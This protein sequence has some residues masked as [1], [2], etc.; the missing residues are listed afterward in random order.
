VPFRRRRGGWRV[1]WRIGGWRGWRI[2]GWHVHPKN[3][4]AARRRGRGGHIDARVKPPATAF[5]RRRCDGSSAPP[6]TSRPARGRRKTARS[7]VAV[8]CAR[9][10]ASAMMGRQRC[11]A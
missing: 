1:G 8:G 11:N 7:A 6:R 10:P 9:S 2:G 5:R 3:K 4:F